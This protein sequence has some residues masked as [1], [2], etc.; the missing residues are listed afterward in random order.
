MSNRIQITVG[1]PWEPDGQDGTTPPAQDRRWQAIRDVLSS[2]ASEVQTRIKRR[3]W[4][5]SDFTI[6]INR[7]RGM[8]GRPLLGELR[9]RVQSAH[10]LVMDIGSLRPEERL[11]PNVLLELG[12]ALSA[13]YE[14]SGRVFVLM[15]TGLDEPSDLRGLLMCRY[16]VQDGRM[17]LRDRQGFSAAVRSAI[18]DAA[19]EAGFLEPSDGVSV[20]HEEDDSRT[21][22]ASAKKKKAMGPRRPRSRGG[23]R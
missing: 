15:P 7:L 8:H 12:M 17:K 4:R 23:K 5:K 20:E 22:S 11:N 18:F 6:S 3:T 1:C 13:H 19:Y 14:D 16:D 10:V 9:R 21:R 2:V